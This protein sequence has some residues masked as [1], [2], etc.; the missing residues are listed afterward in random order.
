M[1]LSRRMGGSA[2]IGAL[3]TDP[4]KVDSPQALPCA[5]AIVHRLALLG[6]QIRDY[7]E[8]LSK[9]L[10]NWGDA[11]LRSKRLHVKGQFTA[12]NAVLP[13]PEAPIT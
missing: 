1:V 11:I 3:I 12:T 5:S 9:Q 2:P 13:Y 8:A 7:G 10:I 4:A 6:A